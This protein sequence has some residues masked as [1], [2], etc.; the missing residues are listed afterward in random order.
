MLG[1]QPS[2]EWR[3]SRGSRQEFRTEEPF[4]YLIFSFGFV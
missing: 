2:A 4:I 3:Y 1:G